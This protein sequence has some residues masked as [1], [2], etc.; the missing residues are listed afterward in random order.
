MSIIDKF[1]SRWSF[2]TD[3]HAKGTI[4]TAGVNFEPYNSAFTSPSISTTKKLGAGSLFCTSTYGSGDCVVYG[5]SYDSTL[6]GPD[7]KWSFSFWVRRSAG[8]I[9][10]IVGKDGPYENMHGFSIGVGSQTYGVPNGSICVSLDFSDESEDRIRVISTTDQA[11]ATDTWYHVA[12]TYDG[13]LYTNDGLDRVS[14]FVN[15]VEATTELTYTAGELGSLRPSDP[16]IFNDPYWEKVNQSYFSI[17]GQAGYGSNSTGWSTYPN[18]GLYAL[19]RDVFGGYIDEVVLFNDILTAGEITSLYNAGTGTE[20]FVLEVNNASHSFHVFTDESFTQVNTLVVA[21]A[22]HAITSAEVLLDSFN[23]DD[24]FHSITSGNVVLEQVQTLVVADATHEHT[25]S[26]LDEDVETEITAVIELTLP[27]LEFVGEAYPSSIE[28]VLTLPALQFEGST[29]QNITASIAGELPAIT[30]DAVLEQENE[31]VINVTLPALQFDCV[32]EQDTF[33]AIDLTLPA[34]QFAGVTEQANTVSISA[35][36]PAIGFTATV[37]GE[38]TCTIAAT[39][40]ALQFAATTYLDNTLTLNVTLP[41]LQFTADIT[42]NDCT[43]NLTLPAL[44]FAGVLAQINGA[45]IDLTLPTL[46]MQGTVYVEN[47]ISIA[48]TLPALQFNGEAINDNEMVLALTLPAL[49]FDSEVAVENGVALSVTLP[50]LRFFMTT[51]DTADSVTYAGSVMNVA[52]QAI[53]EY[54][55]YAFNSFVLWDG[56]YYGLAAGGIYLLEGTDDAG[57]GI[58][59]LIESGEFDTTAGTDAYPNAVRK[60]REAWITGD[61]G[62]EIVLT[63]DSMGERIYTADNERVKFAKGIK[64]RYYTI[65][66]RN[67][68]GANISLRNIRVK[69]DIV[70]ERTR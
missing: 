27:A 12:V 15:N 57:T 26:E 9:G 21:N 3:K 32:T 37:Y 13:S 23:A 41:A 69:S 38:N 48:V 39:L 56:H 58:D 54:T 62:G 45:A 8:G 16:P 46:Q 20:L 6:L 11:L 10:T 5:K 31:I 29:S 53:S 44:Q 61:E 70:K 7:K 47:Q 1:V 55:N 33:A 22:S 36:L 2:N 60:W 43:I 4:D 28:V 64:N 68:D 65:G 35:T 19:T 17:G 63:G 30:M 40:P 59:T 34:L 52:T 66:Y 18:M 51:Y 25:T 14:V 24:S 50:A 67:V 49:Q 42:G